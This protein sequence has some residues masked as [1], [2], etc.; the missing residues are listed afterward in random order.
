MSGVRDVVHVSSDDGAVPDGDVS[1]YPHISDD[2]GV[3]G[4]KDISLAADLKIVEV[5]DIARSVD[6]LAV[7][8][9][10]IQPVR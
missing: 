10:G 9:G 3:G 2:G 8:P 5:H 6:D 7:L 4:N 1:A